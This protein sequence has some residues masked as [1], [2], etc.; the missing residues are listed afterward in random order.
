MKGQ[1]GAVASCCE[2]FAEERGAE[3]DGLDEC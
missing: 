3:V 2:P 1:N